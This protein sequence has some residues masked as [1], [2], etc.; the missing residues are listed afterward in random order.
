M[1]HIC[2]LS[3]NVNSCIQSD[4][5]RRP[6]VYIVDDAHLADLMLGA[7][8]CIKGKFRRAKLLELAKYIQREISHVAASNLQ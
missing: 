6:P 2:A 3:N 4:D 8:I 1:H 7:Q 5:A